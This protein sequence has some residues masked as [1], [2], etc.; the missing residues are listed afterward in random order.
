MKNYRKCSRIAW[1]CI[2]TTVFLFGAIGCMANGLFAQL[3]TDISLPAPIC[4]DP[5]I[6]RLIDNFTQA[7]NTGVFDQIGQYLD[8]DR[9][10][11]FVGGR[12]G[13][14]SYEEIRTSSRAELL[15]YFGQ[16]HAHHEEIH[17]V[18]P[19]EISPDGSRASSVVIMFSLSRR[20]DDF[21][22]TKVAGKGVIDCQS[23]KISRWIWYGFDLP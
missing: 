2:L 7:Y 5:Q 8:L 6:T 14:Q 16:R 21:P 13:N 15:A 17:Q 23:G 10:E 20:A 19:I 18:E 1:S 12:K 9:F 3:S 4:S 22:L 11:Y